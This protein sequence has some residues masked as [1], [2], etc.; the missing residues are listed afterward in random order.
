M[1]FVEGRPNADDGEIKTKSSVATSCAAPFYFDQVNGL[2]DGAFAAVNPYWVALMELK[3]LAMISRSPLDFIASFGTGRFDEG[4][5]S[6]VWNLLPRWMQRVKYGITQTI[7]ADHQYYSHFNSQ[8]DLEKGKSHR[9]DPYLNMAP[10][11]L[12]QACQIDQIEQQAR[13]SLDTDGHVISA[14]KGLQ[15]SILASSF[16]GMIIDGPDYD[17]QTDMYSATLSIVSRWEDSESIKASLAD[18]LR[19]Y[20]FS[21]KG[22]LFP[23]QTPLEITLTMAD[24]ERPIDIFL[25]NG[26]EHPHP[27][28]GFPI[29][30]NDL[31]YLQVP[32]FPPTKSAA[33]IPKRRW[34]EEQNRF[35]KVPRIAK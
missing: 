29:S 30:I 5:E 8:S 17:S 22:A 7:N 21:V 26:Y 4:R 18:S 1:M 2:Q 20:S 35:S 16:Y 28:S 10:I 24:S 33:S 25:V 9:I 23:Y 13:V 19:G 34:N 14:L 3:D 11:P 32:I 12:D 27:I 31:R 15:L 6:G